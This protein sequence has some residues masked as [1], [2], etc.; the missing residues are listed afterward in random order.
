MVTDL[1]I[2]KTAVEKTISHYK[3]RPFKWGSVDCIKIS[4]YL[5]IQLG[6]KPPR[7]PRYSSMT[8]ALRALKKMEADS[9]EGL[10]AK[11]FPSI[12]VSHA[13]PG[14]LLIGDAVQGMDAVLISAGRWAIGF[15]E[16]SD[17]LEFILPENIKSAYR[18]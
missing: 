12:P 8:G 4:R 2:R 14:D 6:H 9:C 16:D 11:Y 3:D 18:L 10:I 5:A 17:V 7:A 1:Q 13:L 15:H